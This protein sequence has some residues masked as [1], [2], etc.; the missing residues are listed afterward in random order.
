MTLADLIKLIPDFQTIEI[1]SGT[2]LIAGQLSSIKSGIKPE[3][4]NCDVLEVCAYQD[5]FKIWIDGNF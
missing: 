4:C 5:I 1:I 3:W 2:R